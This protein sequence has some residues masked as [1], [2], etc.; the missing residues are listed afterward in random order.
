MIRRPTRYPEVPAPASAPALDALLRQARAQC[1]DAV[2]AA[3]LYGSCLRGGDIFDGILDMYLL[4]DSYPAAYQRRLPAFAN[5]LL[6]PNVFYLEQAADDGKQPSPQAPPLADAE[7][8][9]VRRASAEQSPPNVADDGGK[10]ADGRA[11]GSADSNILRCKAAVIS[12]DDFRDGCSE[13]WF[14]SYIWGRF[15][16]P[17]HILYSR[18]AQIRAEVEACLLSACATLLARSLPALPPEGGI[19]ELWAGALALSYGTELRAES[20]G[21]PAALAAAARPFYADLTQQLAAPDGGFTL[22]EDAAGAR[23]RCRVPARSRRAARGQWR[24]RRAQGKLL[25]ILRLVKALFTYRG[26]LDYIAWKL[27]RHAGEPIIIP[28]KLRRRPLIHLWPFF[29]KLYRRGL[30]K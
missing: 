26:G 13:R 5:R 20:P 25:S 23:Y 18:D 6:P 12:L 16:Q 8:P 22:R 2:C 29:W 15:A 3:L 27:E 24:R 11:A 21:R 28:P 4:V 30:F 14:Q 7:Q 1:N 9:P 19:D 10:P 17:A